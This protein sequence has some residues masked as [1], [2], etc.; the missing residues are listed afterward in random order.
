MRSPPESSFWAMDPL[1]LEVHRKALL[2]R[3][4]FRCEEEGD[5]AQNGLVEQV[6]EVK[7]TED[8]GQFGRVVTAGI[9]DVVFEDEDVK[10]PDG[11]EVELELDSKDVVAPFD[12]DV[13]FA[14]SVKPGTVDC[15]WTEGVG[16]LLGDDELEAGK[17]I[18]LTARG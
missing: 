13:G 18:E 10:V 5:G 16:E 15:G 6:Q 9:V 7:A 1:D 17:E 4:T 8:S 2:L 12:L 14:V 11:T 3:W